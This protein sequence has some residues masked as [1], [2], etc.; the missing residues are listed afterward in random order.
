MLLLDL[1]VFHRHAHRVSV[2]E[3]AFWSVFWIALALAFNVAIYFWMGGRP[4]RRSHGVLDRKVAQR[5]QPLRLR[6]DLQLL[7]GAGGV[8]APRAVLGHPGR[9]GDAGHADLRWDQPDQPVPLGLLP[10]RRVASSSRATACCGTTRSGRVGSR[11]EPGGPDRPQ[12][13]S[14]HPGLRGRALVQP[15]RRGAHATPLF[16]VLLLVESTDLVFAIDSIPAIFAITQD[17]FIV[18][19]SNVFAILGL[20]SLYFLLAARPGLVPLP[21]QGPGPGA[22]VHRRQDAGGRPGAHPGRGLAGRGPGVVAVS[23]A[24]S[25]WVRAK[26]A[27]Q[28]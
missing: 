25:L 1:G 10:L 18:Y 14:R 19:T 5:R 20:R 8:P 16:V 7:P 28:S 27:P 4:R 23:I 2:R 3:A 26:E 24:L 11:K 22:D 9:P 6:P 13:D 21:Q 12:G 15:H 17:P